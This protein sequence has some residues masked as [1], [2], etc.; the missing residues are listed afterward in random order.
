[1]ALAMGSVPAGSPLPANTAEYSRSIKRV[2]DSLAAYA[3]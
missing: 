3:R 1:M 2:W